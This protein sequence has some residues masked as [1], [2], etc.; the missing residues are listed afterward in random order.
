MNTL[1]FFVAAGCLILSLA[2]AQ[3]QTVSGLINYQGDTV[4]LELSGQQNWD[5][6][7]KRLEVKNQTVVE[8]TVPAMDDATIKALSSFKSDFV[9][10]VAVDRKGPDGKHVISFTLSGDDIDTFDYLTDQPSRLIMDFYVNPN[11]K[12]KKE[13]KA[14]AKKTE[15][16]PAEESAKPAKSV[17]KAKTDKKRK[18]A[19]A[20]VLNIANQGTAVAMNSDP[21]KSGIFDG[22]DPNYERFSIKDYEIKEEALIRAKDNYYIPFPMLETPVSYWEKMKVT[23]TIYEI[24]AKSSDENKQA[25]L[26]LT[27]FEK[28]RYAVYLKTQNWFKDKYPKSEYNEIIDYMTADVHLALWQDSGNSQNYDEAVQRYKEAIEK[29]PRSPLAER[30]SLKIGYLAL[31]KGDY[32]GALRLFNEHIGNK[33]FPDKN[34]LSKDL[35]RLGTA[36]AYM[37][38]NRYNEAVAQF[39][40]IEKNSTNRDLKVEAA[41]RRGDVWVRGKNYSRAVEEYQRALK[42]Y[43]EGQNSYPN[44]YYNQAESLFWMNKYNQSLDTYLEFIKKFPSNANA[45]YAMTRMGELLDIFGADKSRVMGAYLETYFRYGESPSAVIS[46]LRL[47]SGRMKGMKPKEVNNAVGEIMSLA[48]KVDLPNMEQFATVMVADGYTQR[49][50]FQKSIDLLSKYYKEH[51]TSVDVPLITNR[52]ISNINAKLEAEVNRGNFI[53][54]LKTHSQY[55]DTWL[56]NSKRLDTRYNV[57]RAFEM[58]GA[59]V[60]AEKYYKDVLN[61]VY[62]IRGTPE[63]KEVQVKE[64]IPTE[65]ELNLRLAAVFT[66]EG[67]SNLGYEYL[68]NIKT[69][70]KL[71][72]AAQIER[73]NIAVRLLE[74]R[75]DNESAIRY[76][77]ELLRTWKGQPELV[78]EPYLKLAELQ[79]KQNRPTEALQALEVVD[80]LQKD[81]GKVSTVVHAKALENIGD[82]YLNKGDEAKATEAYGKLLQKY[83][84]SRPLSSIRYKLGQIYFKRGEV[85]KAAEVWNEFKGEKSGFWKNLAQEQLKNSEWRDG[86]KKYIQRI[87][88]M[89][90]NEQGQ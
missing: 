4:H 12:P 81:S 86:Y 32:L 79:Q 47:L 35:A 57:G 80:Q 60:E 6:D 1:R 75:G 83:E 19:T 13:I 16:A 63:A 23:P 34:A 2:S 15:T 66:Q 76:L 10:G 68:K 14:V 25:R 65:D 31:E 40:D 54:A 49:N 17:A 61:R 64:E 46:R 42:K 70:E 22:G 52:I 72:E 53:E 7:V 45:P 73:V 21:V 9:T 51:P 38:L 58:G 78:A 36:L 44:A 39:D 89:S 20:D 8:M 77:G 71:S 74:K 29:Y 87:P 28:Q 82:L 11:S 59:P 43:P 30:T 55:A 18:P 90:E 3:A 41:F 24:S 62:A 84:E 5:Y 67:K 69:P 37:K 48:K 56:K 85:Q 88:A 26:L 27:L 33:N 50:E